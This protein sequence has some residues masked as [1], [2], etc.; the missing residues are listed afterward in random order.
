[1]L[2]RSCLD[3]NLIRFLVSNDNQFIE[4]VIP[5]LVAHFSPSASYVDQDPGNL[6]G[7]VGKSVWD[8]PDGAEMADKT[9]HAIISVDVK[10]PRLV[11]PRILDRFISG[12][13]ANHV[14]QIVSWLL[15]RSI[16]NGVVDD[17]FADAGMNLPLESRLQFVVG[18]CEAG[19]DPEELKRLPFLLTH[20][21]ISWAG[22]E[23][24]VI[25]ERIK[26]IDETISLLRGIRY[27]EHR[28]ILEDEKLKI[29]GYRNRVE[30]N[31]FLGAQ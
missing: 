5:K 23:V 17:C 1:M 2:F 28:K 22:S 9:W 26:F 14:D 13:I 11:Y 19:I 24:P 3:E 27:V 15:S 10:Y 20:R 12:A 16:V 21:G 30:L 4:N 31:E 8:H 18:L 29:E 6:M 7:V 25:N